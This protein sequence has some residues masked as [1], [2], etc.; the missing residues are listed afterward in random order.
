MRVLVIGQGARE[1]ALIR[2]LHF[3]PSVTEIHVAPGS[4]GMTEAVRHEM[5][6]SDIPAT[7]ELCRKFAFDLIVIGPETPL[8]E[9]L[10][11]AL[12]EAGHTVFGPSREAANLEGSKI[13]CKEFL[14]KGQIPTAP[15]HIVNSVASTLAAAKSYQPPF[16]LKADGL[17][18]GKGVYICNTLEE[19][20]DAAKDMFE[21]KILGEAGSRALLEKFNKGFEL[22][23][24]ILT[25]GREYRALPLAQDHKKIFEGETG[26]NTGGMG[27]I[28]P[29]PINAT[30]HEA[31]LK[32]VVEPT[33]EHLRKT[34]LEY[35][36][37]LFIGLM[38]TS[39]GPSVLE[40]NTR[41]GDPEA[42]VLLPLLDGDWGKVFHSVA[43]GQMTELKWKNIY[44][45]CVVLAAEGYPQNAVKGTVIS[46]DLAG[47]TSSSYVLHAGTKKNGSQ[48]T[49]NGGRV[50][51][52]VGI[53]STLREAI[54]KSYELA[55]T[56]D[57]PGKQMRGD[58][59]KKYL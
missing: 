24:F 59:G 27:T 6:T 19:L 58:I 17:A 8:V 40:F 10:S 35:R 46:G 29:I 2:A 50:L 1:H 16:V 34:G 57:W 14:V 21:R 26:P 45:A 9:G 18:A 39:D 25:N 51:S 32:K 36:G 43:K 37:V 33:V 52:V 15:F 23:Y 47:Q 55:E 48:W 3:S 7:L 4:E 54:K 31:I 53:G 41:F 56:I 30:D 20:E 13:Y 42:Q 5:N 12:R 11:D 22:S 38:M 44:A 49:V 28:A